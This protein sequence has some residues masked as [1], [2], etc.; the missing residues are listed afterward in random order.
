MPKC[1][2]LDVSHP[3]RPAGKIEGYTYFWAYYVNGY[4]SDKHCQPC[5][6]GSPIPAFNSTTARTG[7]EFVFDKM[8]RYP[9]VYVCGV[10]SGAVKERSRKNFHLALRYAEGRSVSAVTYNGY[11]VTAQNAVMLQIPALPKNWQPEGATEPLP[12][13]MTRCK[14]FQFAVEYFG[15]PSPCPKVE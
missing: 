13:D 1:I 11:I 4:R 15:Y 6:T 8:D 14:N 3:D 10:A 2:T 12:D 9:Y 5:F 7:K